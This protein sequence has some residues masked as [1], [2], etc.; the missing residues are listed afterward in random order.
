MT[1][2]AKRQANRENAAKSTGPRTEEGKRRAS[3]NARRHGLSR[4][5]Q[6]SEVLAWYQVLTGTA[7][8]PVP[9]VR[10]DKERAALALAEAEA[11][12]ANAVREEERFLESL[13]TGENLALQLR[14]VREIVKEIRHSIPGK[15]PEVERRLLARRRKVPYEITLTVR[16]TWSPPHVRHEGLARYRKAAEVRRHKALLAWIEILGDSEKTVS[17]VPRDETPEQSQMHA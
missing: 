11:H 4:P 9:V 5:P 15:S 7:L 13:E 3:G 17:N 14:R 6:R 1:S 10:S 2:D 16:E 12:L 8:D